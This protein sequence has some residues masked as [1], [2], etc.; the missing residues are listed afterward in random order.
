MTKPT[1]RPSTAL[2]THHS[3]TLANIKAAHKR[4][5]RELRELI[6]RQQQLLDQVDLVLLEE[7]Q[8]VCYEQRAFNAATRDEPY[9]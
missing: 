9:P 6:E 4:Q 8:A 7:W 1:V 5:K 2:K 3:K